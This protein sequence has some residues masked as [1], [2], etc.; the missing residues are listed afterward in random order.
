PGII[1]AAALFMYAVGFFCKEGTGAAGVAPWLLAVF[2]G[3][4]ALA[5]YFSF[6][7][8]VGKD[9]WKSTV[10]LMAASWRRR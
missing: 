2:S 3:M 1:L 7:W 9:E 6:L 10:G 8:L 5:A 4:V